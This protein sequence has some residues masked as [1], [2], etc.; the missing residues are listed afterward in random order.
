MISNPDILQHMGR[1]LDDD[2]TDELRLLC[3]KGF[4]KLMFLGRVVH[5]GVLVR[6]LLLF[7]SSETNKTAKEQ[8][9]LGVF[10]PAYAI[11]CKLARPLL[12]KVGA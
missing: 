8:Q 2:V 11:N 9:F 7:F 10:F 6:L 12:E 1:G 4:C 3:T 5:V